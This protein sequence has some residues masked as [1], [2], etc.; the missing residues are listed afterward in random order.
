MVKADFD[1]I[2]QCRQRWLGRD[3]ATTLD[4][5]YFYD[6]GSTAKVLEDQGVLIGYLFGFVAQEWGVVRELAA[7]PDRRGEGVGLALW[8]AFEEACRDGGCKGLKAVASDDNNTGRDFVM[9]RG[10]QGTFVQ[11]YAGPGRGRWVYSCEF[12]PG[13]S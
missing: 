1:Q 5:T 8:Q 3:A 7:H 13:Q 9:R 6:L 11:D 4:P 12:A 10:L 2:V